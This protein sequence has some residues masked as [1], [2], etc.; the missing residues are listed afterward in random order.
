MLSERFFEQILETDL[1]ED[2]FYSLADTPLRDEF[3]HPEQMREADTVVRTFY[4]GVLDEMR[5]FSP[6]P[7]VIDMLRMQE[8]I[9]SLK[10][11]VKRRHMDMDIQPA[12]SRFGDEA[13][14]RL[15]GGMLV[16]LPHYLQ[17]VAEKGRAALQAQPQHLEVLEAAF[18]SACLRALCDTAHLTGSGFIVEYYRRYDT[19]KGVELLWRARGMGSAENIERLLVQDRQHDAL[20]ATLGSADMAQWPAALASDMDGLDSA[21][22][23]AAADSERIRE[24]VRAA[25]RW[26]MG[27]ARQAKYV[28]FGP[29]RVFGC[30]LGLEAEADNLVLVI[31]GRANDIAPDLLRRHLKACYV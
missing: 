24:Y 30:V 7:Q 9:R 23:E 4:H 14:E 8:E 19:A 22:L 17:P 26:L 18:D 15:W 11:F 21:R 1:I 27:F 10:N 28:A 29:E 5:T 31:G 25:E 12:E 13:W 2:V 16:D 6:S 3:A 20:F